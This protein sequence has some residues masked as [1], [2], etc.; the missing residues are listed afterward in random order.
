MYA[1]RSF[2]NSLYEVNNYNGRPSFVFAPDITQLSNDL[3]NLSAKHTK[4]S[5]KLGGCLS[6]I[7]AIKA[8][9]LELRNARERVSLDLLPSKDSKGSLSVQYDGIV[10]RL[11]VARAHTRKLS[12]DIAKVERSIER[13]SLEES[14]CEQELT[15]L[16][17]EVAVSEAKTRRLQFNSLS[18]LLHQKDVTIRKQ[19]DEIDQLAADREAQLF[20]VKTRLGVGQGGVGLFESCYEMS[21][22]LSDDRYFFCRPVARE[23]YNSQPRS[24]GA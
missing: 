5:E 11:N 16:Q 13:F 2:C 14:R 17:L 1:I 3:D 18:K 22:G 9:L 20:S 7:G 12:N 21:V 19:R 24:Y 10:D 8:E 15:R 6:E 4:A 23:T